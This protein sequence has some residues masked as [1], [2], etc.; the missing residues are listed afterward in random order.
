MDGDFKLHDVAE[1]R[2]PEA[3]LLAPAPAGALASALPYPPSAEVPTQHAAGGIRFDFNMGARVVLPTRTDGGLWRVRLRDIDT[4]NILFETTTPGASVNSTKRYFIRFGIEVWDGEA[5]VLEHVYQGRD[6]DVLIQFP[7]GTLG[8]TLA[9]FPYAARFADMHGCR[10]T[11]A[12]SGLII[13]LLRDAYPHIRFVTHEELFEQALAETFYATYSLGLF[14]DDT[15]YNWQPTDFRLVGLHRTAG[16]ILGVSPGEEAPHLALSDEGRPI[17]EPYVCIAVQS[18]SQPKY[19]NNPHG[20]HEVVAFL[21]AGG[22][23]VVCIDQKAIHG[24]GLVW[25][26]I[27]HGV[28]DQTGDR[29]LVERARWL[30]HAALF[31]GTS[32]GLSWLAWAAGCPVV[33]ISGFTQVTNEFSTPYRVINYHACN[34]CWNDVRHRFQHQD[35]LWCPRHAGTERQFECTRLITAEQVKNT[36]RRIPGFE[37]HGADAEDPQ[38]TTSG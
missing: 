12:L 11:C 21:K 33:L 14:F 35:F 27:P 8:D 19:W 32:S 4:G 7:I 10:L 9:W 36:I 25:N 30:K 28:E 31:V 29:P 23:R 1:A 38:L 22:Y 18:S 6:R 26:H 5:R 17:E 24:T 15:D 13:P 20:W 37:T 3:P 34:S 2:Q 16:Y